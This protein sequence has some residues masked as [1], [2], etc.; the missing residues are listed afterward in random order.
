MATP[1]PTPRNKGSKKNADATAAS[2][3]TSRRAQLAAQRQAEAER[4]RKQKIVVIGL[5]ALIGALV[6]ALA[7][8]GVVA[9]MKKA[10]VTGTPQHANGT[11]GILV[12]PDKAKPGAPKV[13]LWSDFQC[14]ACK[15]FEDGVGEE[16]TKLARNGDITLEIHSL[17]FIEENF[18]QS[19]STKANQAAACADLSAI[20][21]YP[22]TFAAIYSFQPAKEGDGFTEDILLKQVPA[23]AGITGAALDAYT[24]CYKDETMKGF[25]K[26]VDA[27]GRTAIPR[28]QKGQWGT[29]TYA[30]NGKKLDLSPLFNQQSKT[31][32]PEGLLQ[33][34]QKNA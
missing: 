15:F 29:P 22:E 3:A 24:K 34:I 33:L 6:I 14:P 2:E 17:T 19:W 25:V 27:A 18:A 8:W 32:Q 7:I 9:S 21:K 28:D 31:W 12:A 4:A 16:L 20:N 30:V 11:T 5:G 10:E 23:K 13:E 26:A 1:P